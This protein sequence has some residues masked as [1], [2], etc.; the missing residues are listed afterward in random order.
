MTKNESIRKFVR[1]T[2][3]CKCP[4]NVFAQIDDKQVTSKTSPHTRSITIGGKLLLYVWEVN[5]PD[6]LQEGIPAIL[7]TGKKARNE[8]GLNRFR[9]I[10]VTEDPSIIKTHAH[11]CFSKFSDLDEKMHLHVISCQDLAGI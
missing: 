1:N 9:A 8:L 4:D 2:L 11:L 10:L 5:N 6:Q 3:G 7:A